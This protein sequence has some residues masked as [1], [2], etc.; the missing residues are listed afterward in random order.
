M[1]HKEL[2]MKRGTVLALLVVAPA[3]GCGAPPPR[4]EAPAISPTE[5]IVAVIAVLFFLPVPP[6]FCSLPGSV[7]TRS[8]GWSAWY[9]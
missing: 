5:E 8:Y 2:S 7:P 9:S 6:A 1:E 3:V 4:V